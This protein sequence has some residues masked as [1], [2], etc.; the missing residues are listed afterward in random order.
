M[1]IVSSPIGFAGT[2]IR[3]EEVPFPKDLTGCR[4]YVGHPA[5]RALLE[6]L[7]AETDASGPNGAPGKWA[8]PA[9]GEVYLAVPLAS[10]PRTEGWTPNVAIETVAQL[11]AIRCTRI[12]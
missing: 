3:F 2:T 7:G 10:N 5:T 4:S 11:R 1:V 12:E 9:V 8:G 6:A